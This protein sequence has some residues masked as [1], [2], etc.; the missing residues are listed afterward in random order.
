[1]NCFYTPPPKALDLIKLGYNF[2]FYYAAVR[3]KNTSNRRKE[4]V[5]IIPVM[6]YC[7]VQW[8]VTY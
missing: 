7:A 8:C 1:M 5:I 6:P 4:E 3:A 2:E